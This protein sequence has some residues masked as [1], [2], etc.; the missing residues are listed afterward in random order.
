M[1]AALLFAAFALGCFVIVVFGICALTVTLVE[2]CAGKEEE[3]D[4]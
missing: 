4:R 1:I 2:W 3:E